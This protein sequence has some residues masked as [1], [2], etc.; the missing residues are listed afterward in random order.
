MVVACIARNGAWLD[1]L[2]NL[3]EDGNLRLKKQQQKKNK[4]TNKQDSSQY[5]PTGNWSKCLYDLAPFPVWFLYRRY[6][7][8]MYMELI[9]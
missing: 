4:Q 6:N 7:V 8:V 5:L 1:G 2:A 3:V 9:L